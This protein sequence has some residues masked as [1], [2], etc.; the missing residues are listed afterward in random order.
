MRLWV[1]MPVVLGAV[2]P[3]AA[4]AQQ[5]KCSDLVEAY[6]QIKS[7]NLRGSSVPAR[8]QVMFGFIGGAYFA[9][10][11]QE[12]SS[13]NEPGLKEFE[14]QVTDVC[15]AAPE[16]RFSTVVL[17]EANGAVA[18]QGEKPVDAPSRA[19]KISDTAYTPITKHDS[20]KLYA[21]WGKKW[22]GRINA[23]LEKAVAITAT[24][25]KCD[26]VFL[27]GYS[28]DRSVPK[29]NFSVFVDCSNGERFFYTED[30]A[31]NAKAAAATVSDGLEQITDTD[32]LKSCENLAKE[33]LKFPSTMDVSWFSS[34]VERGQFGISVAL[35]FEAKNGLGNELPYAA[36]CVVNDKGT[37]L[38]SVKER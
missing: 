37:E 11:N 10:T 7:Q 15:R 5:T 16:E 17:A 32:A 9:A 31:K 2:V 22:I 13:E 33:N 20:P 1:V 24:S 30:E 6:D 4:L 18:Y 3:T 19:T 26:R 34:N 28:F 36:Y 8:S 38:L 21:S 23:A 35:S 12:M 14:K 27:S 25:Q 29:K